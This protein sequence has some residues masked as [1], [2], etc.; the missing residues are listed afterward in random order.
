MVAFPSITVTANSNYDQAY[1]LWANLICDEDQ[2]DRVLSAIKGVPV[3][4]EAIRA[5]MISV[6]TRCVSIQLRSVEDL[7]RLL[8]HLAEQHFAIT[9]GID[10]VIE[11]V[12]NII[13]G[14][15]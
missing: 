1:L 7:N 4:G 12:R 8:N 2:V 6:N 11:K 3:K 13:E 14:H 15:K 10:S 5:G 9:D